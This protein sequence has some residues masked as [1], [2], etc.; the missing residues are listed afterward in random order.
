M[1]RLPTGTVWIL[2]AG[3]SYSLGGPL[4]DQFFQ[5]ALRHRMHPTPAANSMANFIAL[6]KLYHRLSGTTLERDPHDPRPWNDPEEFLET[7]DRASTDDPAHAADREIALALIRSRDPN[8]DPT[9]VARQSAI[10]ARQ[11]LVAA[12][13]GFAPEG[14]VT[15]VERWIPYARWADSLG[16]MDA[17]IS[18]NYDRVVERASRDRIKPGRPLR[19][20]GK[21]YHMFEPGKPW[22][23]K[24]HGSIDWRIESDGSI[25]QDCNPIDCLE[26]HACEPAIGSPGPTKMRRTT[27]TFHGFWL[28]ADTV[29]QQARKIVVLGYRMPA[30]D[31]ESK[32]R[33]LDAISRNGVDE[34]RIHLVLG[35]NTKHEHVLRLERMLTWAVTRNGRRDPSVRWVAAEP[36]GA[37]DYLTLTVPPAR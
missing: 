15:R 30:T 10:A 25:T 36:L 27:E 28:A 32:R 12:L 9:A 34:L 18:F 13:H 11:Y 26:A 3:F 37:E 31:N 6:E 24:V 29:L 23:I 7:I 2:G 21:I 19:P 1:A 33:I 20:G 8:V 14:D 16:E 22:L 4:M 17:I 5:P 35:A